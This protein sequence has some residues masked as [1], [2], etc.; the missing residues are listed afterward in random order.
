MAINVYEKRER[1][2][3]EKE[4]LHK[5]LVLSYR[6]EEGRNTFRRLDNV[7]E[8]TPQLLVKLL[9][10]LISISAT[11]VPAVKGVEAIWDSRDKGDDWF[12]DAIFFISTFFSL[13]SIFTGLLSVH[14]YSK[15]STVGDL[16]K[17]LLLAL[18]MIGSLARIISFVFLTVPFLGL[19]GVMQPYTTVSLQSQHPPLGL[20]VP[21]RQHDRHQPGPSGEH[22]GPNLV[23]FSP[24]AVSR[25]TG[26]SAGSVGTLLMVAP[27]L[28][29][30]LVFFASVLLV[31]GYLSLGAREM[32]RS[33]GGPWSSLSIREK[34]RLCYL[35]SIHC[36]TTG[37]VPCVLR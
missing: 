36:L 7:L 37:L 35:R 19:F 11:A 1:E 16:G 18:Y 30:L 34:L 25:Y 3:E 17:V 33:K 31:P 6:W 8:H 13:T 27:L 9:F 10:I 12:A 28:H 2:M 14:I 4:K 24:L 5:I 15:H 23:C 21:I 26:M 29:C 32:G 22:A 20:E